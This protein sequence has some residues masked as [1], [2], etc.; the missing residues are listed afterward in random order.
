[1]VARREGASASVV[2]P[3]GDDSCETASGPTTLT[4]SPTSVTC[5]TAPCSHT[6]SQAQTRH[7]D[8]VGQTKHPLSQTQCSGLSL[9]HHFHFGDNIGLSVHTHD[10]MQLRPNT[11]ASQRCCTSCGNVSCLTQSAVQLTSRWQSAYADPAPKPTPSAA[12]DARDMPPPSA[13]RIPRLSRLLTLTSHRSAASRAANSSSRPKARCL[14]F[15]HCAAVWQPSACNA[16]HSTC[17]PTLRTPCSQ[18]QAEKHSRGVSQHSA[19]LLDTSLT[20]ERGG[21]HGTAR[22]LPRPQPGRHT[23]RGAA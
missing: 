9:V 3:Q 12:V 19:L 20:L 10:V 5:F 7:D 4:A 6:K 1:M 11:A 14:S 18:G 2:C 8:N 16:S 23:Q 17:F 21:P 22:A 13:R 15:E